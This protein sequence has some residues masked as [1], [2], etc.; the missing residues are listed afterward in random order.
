MSKKKRKP[1][2]NPLLQE[3]NRIR[4]LIAS[5]KSTEVVISGNRSSKNVRSDRALQFHRS[6]A[7]ALIR[8]REFLATGQ[9]DEFLRWMESQTK[10]QLGE[11]GDAG[12]LGPNLIREVVG[13]SPLPLA[14]EILWVVAR[15]NSHKETLQKFSSQIDEIERLYWHS[16]W[17]SLKRL[18]DQIEGE[19]GKSLWLT[20]ARIVFQQEFEGLESQ[21]R[22]VAEER[23][24]GA[25]ALP[26]YLAYHLAVRN[27]PTSDLGRY[28]SDLSTKLDKLKISDSLRAFLRLRLLDAEPRSDRE[29]AQILQVAQSLTEVDLFDTLL[30]VCNST[31][32]RNSGGASVGAIIRALERLRPIGGSRLLSIFSNF[33]S[34][35][36]TTPTDVE[37]YCQSLKIALRQLKQ[38]PLDFGVAIAI[39]GQLRSVKPV[40]NFS[41]SGDRWGQIIRRMA[42]I[43]KLDDTYELELAVFDKQLANRR[44]LHS[45]G[46]LR[47]AFQRDLSG[48]S[49]PLYLTPA[50]AHAASADHSTEIRWAKILSDIGHL[51]RAVDERE[52]SVAAHEISRLRLHQKTPLSALPLKEALADARWRELKS[53]RALLALPIAL[54]LCWRSTDSDLAATNLRFAYEEFLDSHEMKSPADLGQISERFDADE[55]IYFLKH[56][57][58]APV[59]DMSARIKTS[60]GVERVRTDVCALLC[61]L[62]PGNRNEYEDEIVKLVHS[63]TLFEGQTVVDSSRVHVDT[64]AIRAWAARALAPEVIRYKALVEAGIGVGEDLDLILRNI[65]SSTGV[66]T[67]L[68]IPDSESDNILVELLVELRSRFLLD[69]QHGL[70]SYLS[71]R[72]RH[73]SMTGYV[74]GPVEEKKLITSRNTKSGRYAENAFWLD[75]LAIT[76]AT[77]QNASRALAQFAE[78]FDRIVLA[79]KND[80]FHVK[81]TEHPKG[82]FD[83]HIL[84]PV[85]HLARSAI[86][87]DIGVEPLCA[88]SFSMFWAILEPSLKLA[89]THLR[90][91]TKRATTA[92]FQRLRA[93]LKKILPRDKYD[94][95]SIAIGEASENVQREIDKMADWFIRRESQ[96]TKQLYSLEKVV[97]ISIA[98]A[99]ASHRPFENKINS[100]VD[101]NYY[102]RSGDLVVV[103]ELILTMFGNVKAHSGG[104][105]SDI[106]LRLTCNNLNSIV[107]RVENRISSSS[108]TLEANE[109]VETIRREIADGTY[110]ARIREEG[111][112]GLMKIAATAAQSKLGSV[113]FGYLGENR[114]FVEATLSFIPETSWDATEVSGRI[115]G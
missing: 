37:K 25:R 2:R 33:G 100:H 13:A 67:Y 18:L 58:V 8:S 94:D 96:Q 109:R 74:R 104:D 48:I 114:F 70:D 6:L 17:I 56:V 88:I 38:Q 98:S 99:L 22:V 7:A 21:K 45:A 106:S 91:D 9:F 12:A 39:A 53:L 51:R 105:N 54:H 113:T 14:K 90:H 59:M 65:Q 62:D 72:V 16:D 36:P 32:V 63:Q 50:I 89:Q 49:P 108:I 92:V 10:T 43:L 112:T 20:E 3:R 24:A 75:R 81:S 60:R 110:V 69:P 27:E 42:I 71:R 78:D 107:L 30:A 5:T 82:I 61:E 86:K 57:C 93:S 46:L 77:R 103:A 101:C 68:Q 97:E 31:L 84:P 34:E 83:I 64:A 52:I 79:L 41:P 35:P 4:G 40:P 15:L 76:A 19:F 102:V 87:S 1:K 80:L 23:K 115:V 55:L 95:I 11:L 66:A 26:G 44:I 111:G 73:H 47:A 29:A 28:R 85:V